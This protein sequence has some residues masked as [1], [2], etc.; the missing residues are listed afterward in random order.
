MLLRLLL[1]FGDHC[2]AVVEV[3]DVEIKNG[4]GFEDV[5]GESTVAAA[6]MG[7]FDV[8]FFAVE[9][10]KC[11]EGEE[12]GLAVGLKGS[13]PVEAVLFILQFFEEAVPILFLFELA[14]LF[15]QDVHQL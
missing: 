9:V 15:G 4:V 5:F 10:V 11:V 14:I 3:V 1:H 12:E 6:E 8:F 13:V 2:L 7:N